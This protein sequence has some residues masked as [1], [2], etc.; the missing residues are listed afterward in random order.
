MLRT[1][2]ILERDGRRGRTRPS[3]PEGRSRVI[4]PGLM[5][6]FVLA[7][8]SSGNASV[9]ESKGTRV[10]V[11]AGIGPR[12]LARGLFLAGASGAPHAIVVTHAHGDHLG[13]YR[14]IAAKHNIPVYM[15]ESTARTAMPGSNVDLRYFSPRQPFAI[16]ALTVAPLPLP[17]DAAQVSLV[18]SD[19]ERSAGIATDLGEVPPALPAHLARCDVLLIESNHDVEMVERGPYPGFLKRRILSARGHLSNE[20]TGA[21]LRSLGGATHTVVL[22]HLSKTNNRPDLAL[23]CAR[24]A[25]AGR[26]VRLSVAPPSEPFVLDAALPPPDQALPARAPRPTP[27]AGQGRAATRRG[28]AATRRDE[29]ARAAGQLEL[30]WL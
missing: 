21:L 3:F 14:R 13:N 28:G 11:D 22:M 9:F 10:L 27:A 26:R 4:I 29:G 23:D 6:V 7:S 17:H 30:P 20:Q 19:G 12:T 2:K 15:T 25:L 18:L 24:D 1:Q 8:G 16:G 5:K